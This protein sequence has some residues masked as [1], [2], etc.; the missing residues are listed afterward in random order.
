ME[1]YIKKIV[2]T[3]NRLITTW[4]DKFVLIDDSSSVSNIQ[5]YFDYSIN[6]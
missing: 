4:T 2:K 5:D 1:K 3:I 6:K